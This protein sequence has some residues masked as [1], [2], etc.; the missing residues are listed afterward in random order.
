MDT[1]GLGDVDK[2][3]QNNDVRILMLAV[4]VS[5]RC[6]F[7]LQTKIDANALQSLSLVASL[8]KRIQ[9]SD[10]DKHRWELSNVDPKE[11]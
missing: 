11:Y 2:D 3:D 1:E 6:I 5:S 7:N 9:L 10:A 4:L 8:I